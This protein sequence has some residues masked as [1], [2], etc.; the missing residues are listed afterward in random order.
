MTTYFFLTICVR[1]VVLVINNGGIC[2]FKIVL[3]E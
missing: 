3:T 2:M 1:S